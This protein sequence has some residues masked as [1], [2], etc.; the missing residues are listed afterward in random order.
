M[1]ARFTG[2]LQPQ[3]MVGNSNLFGSGRDDRASDQ[4]IP[5]RGHGNQTSCPVSSQDSLHDA[6]FARSI[7]RF[8]LT[9]EDGLRDAASAPADIESFVDN[10]LSAKPR[11]SRAHAID[12]V[13]AL[14]GHKNDDPN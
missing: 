14:V 6:V 9:E 5:M 1:A 3:D 13:L 2:I 10:C 7:S 4:W 12:T 8:S 11:K